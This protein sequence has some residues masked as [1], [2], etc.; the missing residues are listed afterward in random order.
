LLADWGRTFDWRA[1]EG[2]LNARYPQYTEVVRGARMHFVHSKAVGGSTLPPVLLAHGWPS[3]FVE[4]LPLLDRLVD[5]AR[6]GG[7]PADA[8]DVVVPSLPGFLW[9]ELGEGPLTRKSIAESFHSLMVDHLG[10][11]RF[12]AFGGDIGGTACAWLGALYPL[13]VCGIH[14]I[15][16]PFPSSFDSPALTDR[17]Q[18]FLDAEEKYDATDGGYSA[19][20]I[21]RPDTAAAALIDS[22]AG[23]AAWI[24][25]KY[26][27]W[28]DCHGDVESRFDRT[29][30]L[31]ILTLYWAT[32]CI[33]TSFRQYFDYDANPPR[34]LITVPTAVTLSTEPG[35]LN[36]PRSIAERSC[37]SIVSW[38]EPG[39]GGHFL[40][41]EEPELVAGELTALL[42][43]VG[44]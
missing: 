44:A 35:M 20:M 23:L 37:S 14:L 39:H 16:P 12:A 7:N 31:T 9:S 25:D 2:E 15:H 3:S 36:F 42:R 40:A 10:Y 41:L 30:L 17:E 33:G 11:P 32:G 1:A 24:V 6:F 22:P 34:P 27:D 4:M 26:R 38:S 13:E 18:A 8:V 5:P 21:T 19:M 28:S 29:T 43:V